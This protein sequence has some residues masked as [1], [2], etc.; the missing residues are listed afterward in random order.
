M[1]LSDSEEVDQLPS[2]PTELSNP[3]QG[4][5]EANVPKETVEHES[6]VKTTRSGRTVRKTIRYR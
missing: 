4:V 3:E 2:Q 1:I 6:A 5:P